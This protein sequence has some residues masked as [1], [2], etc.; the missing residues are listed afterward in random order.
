MLYT[1][2]TALNLVYFEVEHHI[3]DE[4]H[5]VHMAGNLSISIKVINR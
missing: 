4:I 1:K 3:A 5:T 2:K